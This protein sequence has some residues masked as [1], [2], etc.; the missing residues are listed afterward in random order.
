MSDD[1]TPPDQ[2]KHSHDFERVVTWASAL[3]MAIAAGFLA[4]LKQINPIIIIRFSLLTVMAFF[5]AGILTVL[6]FQWLMRRANS[7]K[8]TGQ[9]RL[10]GIMI[11][12]A[13]LG[14]FVGCVVF[15]IR[16]VSFQQQKDVIIGTSLAAVVLTFVGVLCWRIVRWLE[17]S[18]E[19]QKEDEDSGGPSSTRP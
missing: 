5:A 14:T 16:N 18:D 3:S 12:I 2:S 13:A 15:A 17:A 4:S 7:E 8:P 11:A 1:I 10:W 9:N 19:K 6:F